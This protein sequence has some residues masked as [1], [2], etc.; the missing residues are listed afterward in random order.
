MEQQGPIS[1]ATQLIHAMCFCLLSSMS[2]ASGTSP[3]SCSMVTVGLAYHSLKVFRCPSYYFSTTGLRRC[4]STKPRVHLHNGLPPFFGKMA[5]RSPSLNFSGWAQLVLT[6]CPKTIILMSVAM[7][8]ES[9]PLARYCFLLLGTV[10]ARQVLDG[11][12][13]LVEPHLEVLLERRLR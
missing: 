13:P 3:F 7:A 5:R 2:V 9:T 8:K 12:L 6:G 4:C 11:Y 10:L 1:A